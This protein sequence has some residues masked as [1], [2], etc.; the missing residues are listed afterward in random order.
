MIFF[1]Q[2]EFLVCYL[3]TAFF[4]ANNIGE[5]FPCV[6][7]LLLFLIT[8]MFYYSVFNRLECLRLLWSLMKSKNNKAS[9]KEDGDW[10]GGGGGV[11]FAV[12]DMTLL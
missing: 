4:L 7:L 11:L 3:K 8:L 10:S 5:I 6:L 9:A 12:L 1:H 2:S